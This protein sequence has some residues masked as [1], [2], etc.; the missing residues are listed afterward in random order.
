MNTSSSLATKLQEHVADLRARHAALQSEHAKLD[1]EREDLLSAPLCIEDAKQFVSDYIDACAA[2]YPKAAGWP[3]LFDRLFYPLRNGHSWTETVRKECDKVP[4][5]CL[6]DALDAVANPPGEHVFQNGLRF[7]GAGSDIH[8]VN[9]FAFYFFFGDSVK[10][11]VFDYLDT[12]PPP[13]LPTDEARAG[14]SVAERQKR[15]AAINGRLAD[16]DAEVNEIKAEFR[17]FNVGEVVP[18]KHETRD[19]IVLRQQKEARELEIRKAFN[20]RNADKLAVKF[21]MNLKE[22]ERICSSYRP[23]FGR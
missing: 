18:V 5:L 8:R 1:A 7:F 13:Y 23:A 4:P 10:K 19:E 2:G 16:I 17:E 3:Q 14:Q 21:G 12:L 11:R 9:D 20:G 22:V 15:I 6:R